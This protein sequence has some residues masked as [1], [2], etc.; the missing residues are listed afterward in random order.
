VLAHEKRFGLYR[1]VGIGCLC[2]S[3]TLFAPLPLPIVCLLWSLSGFGQSFA[4]AV[5][6]SRLGV[7]SRKQQLYTLVGAFILGGIMLA[8]FPFVSVMVSNVVATALPLASLVFFWLANRSYPGSRETVDAAESARPNGRSLRDQIPF[9]EDRKR[10][11]LRGAFS[12]MYSIALG[13][14]ACAALSSWLHPGNDVV[15]GLCNVVPA[16]LMAILLNRLEMQTSNVLPS[17]FLPVTG[18]CLLFFS[19]LWPGSGVL[20]CAGVLFVLFGCYEILGSHTA[21]AYSSYDVVRCLWEL[22]SSKAGNSVGFFLGWALAT[23]GLVEGAFLFSR[24]QIVCFALVVVM[25]TL[26]AL[27]FRSMKLQFRQSDDQEKPHL[28]NIEAKAAP[29]DDR[30]YWVRACDKLMEEYRLSPRQREIFLLLAKGRNVQF[31]RDELVLSTATVKSHIYNIYQKM[32]IHSHQELLDIV[33][34]AANA[35]KKQ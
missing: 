10:V 28:E 22:N 21:Y 20:A 17:L 34:N 27:L 18:F 30:G 19:V 13:V 1:M 4:F 33:E 11:L 35:E 9:D 14:V 6:G 24:T 32:D 31:I 29:I 8:L 7:L 25:G 5:W 15:L 26:D 23:F 16:I 3:I 2:L 12:V